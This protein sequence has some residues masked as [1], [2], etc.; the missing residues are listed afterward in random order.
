MSFGGIGEALVPILIFSIPIIAIVGG[1][2]SRIARTMA[3]ARIQELLIQE[4][5][6][7]MEKGI[8]PPAQAPMMDPDV[9][10]GL[11]VQSHDQRVFGLRLGGGIALAVGLALMFAMWSTTGATEAWVWM[12]IPASIGAALFIGS[13]FVPKPR[14]YRGANPSERPSPDRL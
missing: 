12:T 2:G 7:A 6:K 3:R 11:F 1:I 13:F 9:D 10:A 5:I 4:R 14:V 8:T